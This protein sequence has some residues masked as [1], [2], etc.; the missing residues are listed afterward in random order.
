MKVLV[1]GGCGFLGS[2]ICELFIKKNWDVIA[3]DNLTKDEFKRNTYMKDEAR[4][5]NKKLLEELGVNI[6]HGDIRDKEKLFEY[7]ENVDYICH[8]ASLIIK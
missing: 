6:V 4:E 3:F 5:H 1:T 7:C 2:H 8:T